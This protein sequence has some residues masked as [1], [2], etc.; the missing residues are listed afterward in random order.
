[1]PTAAYLPIASDR[2]G[3]CVRTIDFVGQN[4][5]AV[6]L[7]MEI[8][9]Y[10]DQPGSPKLSLAQVTT[11]AEGVRLISVTTVNGVTTSKVQIRINETTMEDNAKIPYS[12]EIGQPSEMAYGLIGIFSG[13]KRTI[14]YGPFVALPTAYGSDAAPANRVWS[15][16]SSQAYA[17]WTTAQVALNND[18]VTVTVEGADIIGPMVIRAEAAMVSAESDRAA[19]GTSAAKA[20]VSE[21]TT[22]AYLA[23]VLDA[24]AGLPVGA[25]LPLQAATRAAMA[26]FTGMPTGRQALLS[27]TGREG[28]FVWN[29][30]N[31]SVPVAAD[32]YQG[33]YVPP[34]A[35]PSGASGAW[36][37]RHTG[38]G[39]ASWF[40]VVAD[41]VTDNGPQMRSAAAQSALKEIVAPAGV[42]GT[43]S[44]IIADRLR[45]AGQ[46]VTT[47]KALASFNRLTVANC[48]VGSNLPASDVR[49]MDFTVDANKVG[50]GL[51]LNERIMPAMM[52]TVTRGSVERVTALNGT[53]YG[54]YGSNSTGLS[55]R[56]C[57][58]YNCQFAFEQLGSTGV[59][60]ENCKAGDGDGTIAVSGYFH[61]AAAS[62]DI[63]WNNCIGIG[64]AIN[65]VDVTAD[66]GP[67]D[68][69]RFINGRIST[70]GSSAGIIV[71]GSNPVTNLD[72]SG[73]EFRAPNG[74]AALYAITSVS[75]SSD[76]VRLFGRNR[77]IIAN[78]G[79][80]L[81]FGG[82]STVQATM[83]TAPGNTAIAIDVAGGSKVVWLGGSI[84][85]IAAPGDRYISSGDVVISDLAVLDPP[86][87]VR[88]AKTALTLTTGWTTPPSYRAAGWR[89]TPSG[90]VTLEGFVAGSG[91]ATT[92]IATLPVGARP[93]DFVAYPV[94]NATGVPGF[95]T[96][97]PTGAITL[98]EGAT[99]GS[100][101]LDG[102]EFWP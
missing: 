10:P 14:A 22:G 93:S 37:R 32:P 76:R 88:V 43:A 89:K 66:V 98:A 102:I 45:G 52:R 19:A 97:A 11:N 65:G 26:A 20:L 94:R 6:P 27:E 83:P 80:V 15:G 84:T 91:T 86:I 48:V 63:T 30:S 70:T 85:A 79:G 81:G 55:Y 72:L 25:T 47:F 78:A 51:G 39:L 60:H 18:I 57:E 2:A 64:A 8:R 41:G 53:G 75:G 17:V 62:N 99:T 16:T 3:P 49:W 68:N 28:L 73:S 61:C 5:N 24:V 36:V 44:S 67:S 4:F 101:T 33:I 54:H 59:Y 23:A 90:R 9:L 56:D 58:A 92:L 12:G 100:A 7:A 77:G 96:I 69:I 71:Q 13:D 35:T 31:H 50:L 1:M 95:V 42:I 38:I 21:N 87:A 46:G 34:A 74:A 40:G 82:N 29:G